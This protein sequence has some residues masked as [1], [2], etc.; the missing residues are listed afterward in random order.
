MYRAFC[1]LVGIFL[2]A[3]VVLVIGGW[4]K[5]SPAPVVTKPPPVVV[6]PGPDVE[7]VKWSLDQIIDRLDEPSPTADRAYR[8]LV[9]QG[10]AGRAALPVLKTMQK[11]PDPGSGFRA[12]L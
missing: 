1:V 3:A 5:W 7:P 9:A 6:Q 12:N 8:E 4:G 10:L 2:T 11:D